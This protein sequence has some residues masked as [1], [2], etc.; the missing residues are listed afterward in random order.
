MATEE[1]RN[2][3]YSDDVKQKAEETEIEGGE[4][5]RGEAGELYVHGL[6]SLNG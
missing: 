3:N 1:N 2:I 5:G 6:I 4:G